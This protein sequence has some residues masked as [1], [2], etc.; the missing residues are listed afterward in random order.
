MKE[1]NGL[2]EIDS[3]S[4][5]TLMVFSILDHHLVQRCFITTR[6]SYKKNY[7]ES[8]IS[9]TNYIIRVQDL[10]EFSIMR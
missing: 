10:L 7:S 6:V 1:E 9:Y 3:K 4:F 2:G 8:F 5:F